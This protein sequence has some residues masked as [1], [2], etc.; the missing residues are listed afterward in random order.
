[1]GKVFISYSHEDET[2]KEM[3]HKQLRVAEN[4]GLISI[5]EDRQIEPGADWL[6]EIKKALN[7]SDVAI[8]LV[9]DSFLTSQFV[10]QTEVPELLKRRE[11]EG[12]KVI[13]LIL[14]HCGWDFVPWL[15][16]MQGGIPDNEPLSDFPM[17]EQ[18]KH[19]TA[20]MR[21]ICNHVES[22]KKTRLAASDSG[23]KPDDL[24]LESN[25]ERPTIKDIDV[26]SISCLSSKD[27]YIK[28]K[29]ELA[30]IVEQA[31]LPGFCR[32]LSKYIFNNGKE[33][34]PELIAESLLNKGLEKSVDEY[35]FPLCQDA[36]TSPD[37]FSSEK[38]RVLKE[39][40]S[41]IMGILAIHDV[42]DQGINKLCYKSINDKHYRVDGVTTSVGI[43]IVIRRLGLAGNYRP[44]LK[45]NDNSDVVSKGDINI[46]HSKLDSWNYKDAVNIILK[47]IWNA[48]ESHLKGSA[49]EYKDDSGSG[50]SDDEI[51]Q[52]NCNIKK[53]RGDF[54]NPACFFIKYPVDAEKIVLQIYYELSNVI[55]ELVAVAY[56][57]SENTSIVIL[58][59]YGINY[60][61]SKIYGRLNKKD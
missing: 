37:V 29:K 1:M 51:G 46:D 23:C 13:P 61:F 21:Y 60:C 43:E 48:V 47:D 2:W 35:L 18:K 56:Q 28:L 57:R 32:S 55:K 16:S 3:L 19:L 24:Q 50:L 31:D 52:L 45:E 15:K 49:F 27:L 11:S 33:V 54:N 10:L 5:W 20:L 40:M 12:L 7:T 4:Q 9:S 59:N 17:P 36:V 25:I 44:D 42:N 38:I 58:D 26:S 39:L 34:A 53:I 30:S 41:S 22:K 14:E 6:P 8:L